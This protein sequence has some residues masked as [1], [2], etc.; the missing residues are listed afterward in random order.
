MFAVTDYGID[1]AGVDDLSPGLTV[2]SGRLGLIQAIARRLITPRGGLFYD[3][4]YGYDVRQFLSG[5]VRSTSEIASGVSA[6]AEKD[7]RVAQASAS[8]SFV[9][10]TLMISLSITDGAGPFPLVL[11]VS[12]VTV[13]IL[14]QAST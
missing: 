5:D 14:N 4:D 8:V 13:A 2:V 1:L 11:Q 9:G 6:E 10:N 12:Q 7:E 3:P